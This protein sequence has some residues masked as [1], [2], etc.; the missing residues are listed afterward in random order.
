MLAG[1][2]RQEADSSSNGTYIKGSLHPHH[3]R[4]LLP[5]SFFPSPSTRSLLQSSYIRCLN[6]K[7]KKLPKK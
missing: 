4:K 2:A 3:P 1:K 5:S 6:T 7:F